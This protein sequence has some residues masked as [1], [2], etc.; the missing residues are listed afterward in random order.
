MKIRLARFEDL[1][2]ILPLFKELDAKHIDNSRD[3]KSNITDERYKRLFK[4][5]FTKNSNLI[6]TIAEENK[7]IIGFSLAKIIIINDSLIFKN[8]SIGEILFIAVDKS[9]KRKG[10]GRKIIADIEERLK[11]KGV[12]KFELLVFSFNDEF[13][14]EKINYKAK[15]TVYEKY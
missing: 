7:T 9:H 12:N 15:Y 6:L 3:I 13:L 14:P 2:Y 8:L 1:K 4:N 10:V 11:Q 5:V